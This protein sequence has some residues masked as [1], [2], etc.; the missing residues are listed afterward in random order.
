LNV[1]APLCVTGRRTRCRASGKRLRM[2]ILMLPSLHYRSVFYYFYLLICDTPYNTSRK[3]TSLLPKM[4]IRGP[5]Y[6]NRC[7]ST[8]CHVALMQ[9][10]HQCLSLIFCYSFHALFIKVSIFVKLYGCE[11]LCILKKFTIVCGCTIPYV[12]NSNCLNNCS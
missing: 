1:D 5:C 2:K 12:V 9:L 4:H 11:L 6:S 7:I 3:I 8:M 10:T